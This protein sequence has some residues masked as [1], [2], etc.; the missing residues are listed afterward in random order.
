[1]PLVSIDRD[2]PKVAARAIVRIAR[3]RA[4]TAGSSHDR[5]GYD[6]R[7]TTLTDRLLIACG[8][9]GPAAFTVAWTTASG[10]QPGYS[11][12]NEHISGLAAPDARN[13]AV[14]RAGFWALGLGTVGFA[15]ALHRRLG[16]DAAGIGPPLLGGAGLAIC[17][18]GALRRDRMSNWPLP[19]ELPRRQSWVNDG[20]D[21]ASV[22]GQGCA[23][24]GLLA[25]AR[26]LRRD[27]RLRD[28]ALPA[29]GA[30]LASSGTMSFFARDVVRPGNGIVQRIGISLPLLFTVE[31]AWRLL[32]E[33]DS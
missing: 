29:A 10:R 23:T 24:A 15:A 30:A 2:H 8:I 21:L 19:G 25:V 18:A 28:L 3:S 7:V 11:L 14:M 33:H 4:R 5:D 20:H 17:A 6:S 9:A 13:P 1:M 27:P 22:V 26:H 12:A 16:G 31:L 32:R